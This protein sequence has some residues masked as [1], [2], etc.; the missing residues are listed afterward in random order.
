MTDDAREWILRVGVDG[1]ALEAG[2]LEAVIAAHR[3]ERAG[4]VGEEPAFELADAAPVDRRG[5][6][7]LFVARHH[8]ALAADALPHVEVEAVLLAR[9]GRALRHAC[10]NVV[11]R[12]GRGQRAGPRTRRDVGN[13]PRLF[14]GAP[15][16]RQ[17]AFAAAQLRR[18]ETVLGAAQLRRHNGHQSWNS[19]RTRRGAVD[20]YSGDATGALAATGNELRVWRQGQRLAVAPRASKRAAHIEDTR[21][22]RAEQGGPRL[23]CCRPRVTNRHF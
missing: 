7:V 15:Q 17:T 16:E 8:A 21:R 9:R 13:L 6:A 2:R 22:G 5:I 4:R 20:P 10:G 19:L 23:R 3:Q 12:R 11:D 18:D 1:T 14:P